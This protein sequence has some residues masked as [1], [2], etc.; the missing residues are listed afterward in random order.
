MSAMH[1]AGMLPPE[2][3]PVQSGPISALFMFGAFD[4]ADNTSIDSVRALNEA[5]IGIK[6]DR[7]GLAVPHH[8][9]AHV[10]V[11]A[12]KSSSAF[13][14]GADPDQPSVAVSEE[15]FPYLWAVDTD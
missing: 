8:L 15:L 2:A 1:L 13:M 7:A 14:F 4:P 9:H 12:D 10:D 3:S 6:E 5:M 11:P